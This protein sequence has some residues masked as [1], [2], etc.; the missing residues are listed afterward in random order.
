MG[1]PQNKRIR[2]CTTGETAGALKEKRGIEMEA[3]IWFGSPNL[4]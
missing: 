3:L 4:N 1:Q 2:R